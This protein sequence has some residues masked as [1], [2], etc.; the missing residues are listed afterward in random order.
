MGKQEIKNINPKVV[1]KTSMSWGNASIC[2]IRLFVRSFD[3]VKQFLVRDV[4]PRKEK[5]TVSPQKL[6]QQSDP[7]DPRKQSFYSH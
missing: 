7:F 3:A 2:T 1:P 5:H 6:P 4:S